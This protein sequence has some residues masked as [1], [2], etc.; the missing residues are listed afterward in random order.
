[1]PTVKW[2][3][4]YYV[5]VFDLARKGLNKNEIAEALGVSPTTLQ[6]WYKDRPALKR[7][8]DKAR[9]EAEKG[10]DPGPSFDEHV[11][12]RLSPEL[13][14]LWN[15]ITLAEKEPNPE[16]L[17]ESLLARHGQ[18]TRQHLWFHALVM[19]GFNP[20]EANRRVGIHESTLKKWKREDPDFL[21]LVEQVVEIKKNF[22]EGGLMKL[23]AAGDSAATIFASRTLNRDR[24]YDPKV[25][26]VH[27][28]TILTAKI[29]L[30]KL[31][32]KMPVEAR[33]ATLKALEESRAAEMAA[34][35][36]RSGVVI[37]QD[38]EDEDAE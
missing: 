5:E 6:Q 24:G 37:D 11:A 10:P 20:S 32:A 8:V 31:L 12:G 29:D 36:A 22:V 19:G 3:D 35:P 26:I 9:K 4:E 27:E 14:D 16:R 38:E 17:L 1:M 33:R 28:G 30:D 2:K 23:V 13:R 15:E 21:Q 34:L 25:T 7:A 18:R